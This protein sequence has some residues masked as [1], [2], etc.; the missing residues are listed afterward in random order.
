MSISLIRR[1]SSLVLLHSP[2]F[3]F[4]LLTHLASSSLSAFSLSLSLHD[5]A[6]ASASHCLL[7]GVMV[8]FKSFIYSSFLTTKL[9]LIL[10]CHSY[11]HGF[12]DNVVVSRTPLDTC[13]ALVCPYLRRETFSFSS[14]SSFATIATKQTDIETCLV[15]AIAFELLELIIIE[16]QRTKS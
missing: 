5:H 4:F 6:S 8:Y 7:S 14:S 11:L 10:R 12:L 3:F 15:A 2:P 1:C 13:V 9:E 16:Q